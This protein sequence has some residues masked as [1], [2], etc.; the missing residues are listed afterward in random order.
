MKSTV[1]ACDKFGTQVQLNLK[2]DTEYKTVPGGIASMSLNLLIL[3]FLC[4]RLTAVL[5]HDDPQISIY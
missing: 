1:R 3:A 2:G 5:T 4:I